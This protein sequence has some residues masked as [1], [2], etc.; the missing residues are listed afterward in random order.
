[1]LQRKERNRT[2]DKLSKEMEIIIFNAEVPEYDT[3]IDY[4]LFGFIHLSTTIKNKFHGVLV[5][6]LSFG[7][8]VYLD[9]WS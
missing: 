7:R 9:S 6:I 3:T 1:M 8:I 4:Y 5:T 2:K